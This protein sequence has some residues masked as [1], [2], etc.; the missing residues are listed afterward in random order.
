MFALTLLKLNPLLP[1][2]QGYHFN[3]ERLQMMNFTLWRIIE[4]GLLCLF[5]QAVIGCK[6]VF[7]IKYRADGTVERYKSRLVAK[8]LL[9]KRVLTSQIHFPL[10]QSLP[11]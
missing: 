2:K 5:H 1:N 9:T 7:T 11:V 10:L 8:V 3:L 4:Y 6:W